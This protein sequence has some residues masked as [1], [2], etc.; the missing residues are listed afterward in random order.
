MSAKFFDKAIGYACNRKVEVITDGAVVFVSVDGGHAIGTTPEQA[1]KLG[2][3]LI[4][5][6]KFS[7]KSK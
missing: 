2:R 3:A 7:E 1:K 4:K 6:G 5:A